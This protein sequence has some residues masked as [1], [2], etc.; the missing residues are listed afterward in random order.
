M[1][2]YERIK[3]MS[4][5]EMAEVLSKRSGCYGCPCED[6]TF[7]KGGCCYFSVRDWLE[8]ECKQ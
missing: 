8:K 7:C 2:N 6:N 1:N 4:I 5:D 3:N